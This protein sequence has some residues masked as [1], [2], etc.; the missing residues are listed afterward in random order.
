MIE[1]PEGNNGDVPDVPAPTSKNETA[2][3]AKI[4]AK[5]KKEAAAMAKAEAKAKKEADTKAKK[6]AEVQ[7]KA[8]LAAMRKAAA[9]KEYKCSMHTLIDGSWKNLY[10][11]CRQHLNSK[12][13]A[14]GVV[15][16]DCFQNSRVDGRGNQLVSSLLLNGVKIDRHTAAS[17][18]QGAAAAAVSAAL[19]AA[20]SVAATVIVLNAEMPHDEMPGKVLNPLNLEGAGEEAGEGTEEP[21]QTTSTPAKSEMDS[22]KDGSGNKAQ[23]SNKQQHFWITILQ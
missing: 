20:R 12:G 9:A 11:V 18:A 14:T 19:E 10:L 17:V 4:A 22:L 7:S 1:V 6:E 3:K 21:Q 23:V 2:T 15:L 8:E 13:D 16:L 5:A